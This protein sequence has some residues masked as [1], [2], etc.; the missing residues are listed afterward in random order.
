MKKY[1]N[2]LT[3][4]LFQ[5]KLPAKTE[6]MSISLRLP[7][8]PN[9]LRDSLAALL[10]Q[11]E[12]KPG[13]YASIFFERNVFLDILGQSNRPSSPIKQCRCCFSYL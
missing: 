4:G 2:K 13:W 9:P 5:E 10:P 7:F 3:G 6:G 12:A 8:N 1:Q 11:L